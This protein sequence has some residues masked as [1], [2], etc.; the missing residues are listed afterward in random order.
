MNPGTASSEP[1]RK[2][3]NLVAPPA[4]RPPPPRRAGGGDNCGGPNVNSMTG[5]LRYESPHAL[6][7][8]GHS[9]GYK[10]GQLKH[11]MRRSVS[12]QCERE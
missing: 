6:E 10:D 4:L 5:H 11:E 8:Q 12:W 9:N 1:G 3:V 2:V 7:V